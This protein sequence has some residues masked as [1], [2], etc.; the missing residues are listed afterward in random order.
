MTA[1]N[2]APDAARTRTTGGGL[3]RTALILG[4]V[5]AVLAVAG[6]IVAAMS[7]GEGMLVTGIWAVLLVGFVGIVAAVVG[8]IALV[9]GRRRVPALIG[10]V[11]AV[12]SIVVVL[13]PFG[14][15]LVLL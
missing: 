11:L 1:Q 4:I 13:I 3:A 8:V 7:P 12:L 5:A 10:L 6:S 2:S 15:D 14:R 9:K